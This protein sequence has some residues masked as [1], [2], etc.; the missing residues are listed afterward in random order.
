MIKMEEENKNFEEDNPK[1]TPTENNSPAINNPPAVPEV[2]MD[3]L[4]KI[5]K[6]NWAISSYVLGLLSI[7]LIIM[8]VRG[9]DIGLTGKTIN[10]N[11]INKFINT[12]LLRDGDA[13]IEN[14]KQESGIYIATVNLDGEMLP[15]YFTKDGNFI[16][17]GRELMPISGDGETPTP[18]TPEPQDVPKSDKPEVEVFI[19]SHCPFGTQI[20]KGII[21]VVK[22]LGDKIDFKLKFV[23][24]VMHGEVEAMEQLNQYC[25]QEEQNDKLI[26]YLECFLK[27]GDGEA[28][29]TEV[30]IDRAKL[31]ACTA[32]T[33]S[34]FEITQNLENKAAWLSGR[35]PL[36]NIHKTENDL[37][38][39]GGSPTLVINGVKASSARD[40]ASLL[41]TI[42]NAFNEAPEECEIELSSEVPSSGFGYEAGSGS[43]SG[44]CG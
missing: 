28:C 41:S 3:F 27:E 42:C 2:K 37:Y 16:T 14:I 25:I 39:V 7:V 20:E 36:F 1:E 10:E 13:T 33:D 4:K 32:R 9:G 30:G 6:H 11:Q 17:Q 38:E 23:Y 22:T 5:P 29:L 40:P 15:L 18:T 43:S 44:S 26:P 8:L 34:E 35:F 19:M 24:F 31:S 21:P 12:Q